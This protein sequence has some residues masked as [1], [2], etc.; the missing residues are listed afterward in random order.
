[1]GGSSIYQ[2]LSADNATPW[3]FIIGQQ[4]CQFVGKYIRMPESY[5]MHPAHC[6]ALSD[7]SNSS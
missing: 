3:C 7:V 2:R 5:G 1:M 6:L 4:S